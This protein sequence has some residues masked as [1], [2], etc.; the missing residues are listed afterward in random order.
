LQNVINKKFKITEGGVISWNGDPFQ[1][2][3]NL[4]AVY[5]LRASLYEVI[6][7][8]TSK[9]RVPVDV[10][11]SMTDKLMN[12]TIKFDINLPTSDERTRNDVRSAIN[13]N[14]ETELNKQVFALMMLG[15]FFPPSD[16][17][18]SGSLGINQN[19]SELLSAQLSNWLS[20]TNEL[21]NL[22]VKYRA[23]DE[24]SSQELQ[25]AMSTQL[26]N[27][28]LSIDGN[29]GVSNNASSASNLVGDVNV[30]YKL[31]ADGRLRLRAFYQSNDNS[32][33]TNLAP[34]TQG[35]GV[36]Y[37]EEFDGVGELVQRYTQ[38]FKKAK[39]EEEIQVPESEPKPQSQRK[40][41]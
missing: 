25:L 13:V 23:G 36:F 40:D 39:K 37:R 22:G 41:D 7:S 27:E 10:K 34:Y 5:K 24:I 3:I 17:P 6:P 19:T 21:V 33:V 26:F 14:N 38:L 12:P 2:D 31:S 30:E 32:A 1:A 15:R 29:F 9:K 4:E 20:Q 16:R 11:L 35:V 8:D 28:R 18:V